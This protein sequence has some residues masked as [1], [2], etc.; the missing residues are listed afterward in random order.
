VVYFEVASS[1]T[2]EQSLNSVSKGES[3]REYLKDFE[4][5]LWFWAVLR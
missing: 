4:N 1:A 5:W 2:L 3:Y